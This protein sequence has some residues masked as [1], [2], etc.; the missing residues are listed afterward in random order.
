MEC[1]R[2]P[3]LAVGRCQQT[4]GFLSNRAEPRSQGSQ[5]DPSREI[6]G[7]PGH[8]FLLSLQ[9][10]EREE[11]ALSRAFGTGNAPVFSARSI[12]RVREVSQDSQTNCSRRSRT[13][14]IAEEVFAYA[15]FKES[16]FD[17]KAAPSLGMLATSPIRMLLGFPTALPTEGFCL[18]AIIKCIDMGGPLHL[19]AIDLAPTLARV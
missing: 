16:E 17:Q 12:R 15:I 7:D 6:R 10:A 13:K 4:L 9:Q 2:G 19:W 8:G 14:S 1:Q 5:G 3:S 18:Q 11:A